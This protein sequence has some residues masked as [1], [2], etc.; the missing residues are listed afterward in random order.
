MFVYIPAVVTGASEGIGRGYALEVRRMFYI[1]PKVYIIFS[2][3]GVNDNLWGPRD[4]VVQ[5]KAV[6]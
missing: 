6:E 5:V 2:C 4:K 3:T 1:V